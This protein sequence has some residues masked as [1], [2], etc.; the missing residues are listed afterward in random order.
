VA[1]LRAEM[2]GCPAE[3]GGWSGPGGR[4]RPCC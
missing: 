1:G 3:Q 2:I 4:R